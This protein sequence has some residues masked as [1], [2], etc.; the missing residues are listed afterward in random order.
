MLRSGLFQATLFSQANKTHF[1][2]APC[3]TYST[4]SDTL[5]L[6]SH[7]NS[8]SATYSLDRITGTP[9]APSYESIGTLT[10]TGGAWA[11][12]G[13][14]ILPQAAP[15]TGASA[16]GSVPCPIEVFD[17][18]V[19]SAPVYRGGSIYYTQTIGLPSTGLTP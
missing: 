1:C 17:A 6:V 15:N 2:T 7:R 18:Q 11:Q 12:P 13:G 16:C 3:V 8:G 10:R 5:Y 19:R 14:E 9:T 4:T